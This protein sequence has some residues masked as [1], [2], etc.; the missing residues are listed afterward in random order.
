MHVLTKYANW[1]SLHR[2]IPGLTLHRS[3]LHSLAHYSNSILSLFFW[4]SQNRPS[5]LSRKWTHLLMCSGHWSPLF[6]SS[7]PAIA[8][9]SIGIQ[10]RSETSNMETLTFSC[11]YKSIEDSTPRVWMPL[12]TVREKGMTSSVVKLPMSYPC[13]RRQPFT[14]IL[15]ATL[16]QVPLRNPSSPLL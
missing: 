15:W 6:S 9:R 3:H 11:G 13:S 4:S 10:K 2:I 12:T 5:G 8:Q 1:P 7:I 16:T 14:M